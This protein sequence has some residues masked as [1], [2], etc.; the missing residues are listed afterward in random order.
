MLL[1]LRA[2]IQSALDH[3]S[4]RPF[5]NCPRLISTV[6]IGMQRA[7]DLLLSVVCDEMAAIAGVFVKPDSLADGQAAVPS[8]VGRRGDRY[9]RP[10]TPQD[11]MPMTEKSAMNTTGG[12]ILGT[13]LA[14]Q[15]SRVSS[16]LEDLATLHMTLLGNDGTIF[17]MNSAMAEFLK[18]DVS[19][20]CGKNLDTL[21]HTEGRA[22]AAVGA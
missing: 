1:R 21:R 22:K 4:C 12:D 20:L 14:G 10:D 5:L 13:A 2:S 15:S 6:E 8:S 7:G 11:R 17:R 16:I 3:S 9:G 18:G 19:S